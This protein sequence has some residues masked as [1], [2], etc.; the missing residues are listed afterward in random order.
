MWSSAKYWVRSRVFVVNNP[1]IP[2]IA[3]IWFVVIL[4]TDP[5][6]IYRNGPGSDSILHSNIRRVC[7]RV[8]HGYGFENKKGDALFFEHAAIPLITEAKTVF[9]FD[10]WKWSHFHLTTF[11][12]VIF[13][14]TSFFFNYKKNRI[15]S[16]S[17][18]FE[19]KLFLAYT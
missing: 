19:K 5:S 15:E 6:I 1:T 17:G 11:R 7:S 14:W 9:I 18:N 3:T 8:L 13:A 4:D 12:E 10:K 16:F 2:F